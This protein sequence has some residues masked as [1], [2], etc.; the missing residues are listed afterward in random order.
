MYG[1]SLFPPRVKKRV[2]ADLSAPPAVVTV[3]LLPWD[4][5]WLV[6]S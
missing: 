2:T 1:S 5:S 3:L 4:S 6:L